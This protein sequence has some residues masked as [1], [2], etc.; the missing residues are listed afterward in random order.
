MITSTAYSKRGD[1]E[2]AVTLGEEFL[3]VTEAAT[4]IHVSQSTI[5]RWINSQELPAYRFGPKR[6]MVKQADLAP[7]MRPARQEK[8]EPMDER[9]RPLTAK[10]QEHLAAAI[11]EAN[12]FRAELLARRDGKPFQSAWEAIAQMR[13]ERSHDRP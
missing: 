1:H 9:E 11:A 7:L 6:I 12:L 4:L 3:T 10:E 13:D 8:G 5:W 2:M